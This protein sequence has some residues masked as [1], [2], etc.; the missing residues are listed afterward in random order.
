MCV[1]AC[2]IYVY[3]KKGRQRYMLTAAANMHT[4]IGTCTPLNFKCRCVHCVW[5]P[6]QSQHVTQQIGCGACENRTTNQPTNQPIDRL[7]IQATNQPATANQP[8]TLQGTAVSRHRES[9]G[10]WRPAAAGWLCWLGTGP[11]WGS[12]CSTLYGPGLRPVLQYAVLAGPGARTAVRSTGPA[13][14]PY[15]STQH[16]PGLG[17]VLQYA[18]RAVPGARTAVPSV[19]VCVIYVYI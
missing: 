1:C 17:P 9:C 8:T 10:C 18:V 13:W 14:G 4:V 6:R 16:G 11:A 5:A 15:C 3:F 7:T 12:Y 19:R 2:V